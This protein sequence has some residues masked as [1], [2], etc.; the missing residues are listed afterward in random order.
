MNHCENIFVTGKRIN[1]LC[2]ITHKAFCC[3]DNFYVWCR[4][5]F[6]RFSEQTIQKYRQ[7]LRSRHRAFSAANGEARRLSRSYLRQLAKMI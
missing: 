5:D 4:T 1:R 6:S 2:A 7:I 3:E